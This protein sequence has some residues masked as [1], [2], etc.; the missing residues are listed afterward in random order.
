[1]RFQFGICSLVVVAV[2]GESGSI[3]IDSICARRST[4]EGFGKLFRQPLPAS[5]PVWGGSR[6]LNAKNLEK[7]INANDQVKLLLLML[8]EFRD[9]NLNSPPP[10][11]VVPPSEGTIFCN[12][13][14][15]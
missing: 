15:H 12:P 3:E 13:R 8:G 5:F 4:F 11:F 14:N 6:A 7:S 1:M 9:W 2:G 10:L